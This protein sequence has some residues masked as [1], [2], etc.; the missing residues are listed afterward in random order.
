MRIIREREESVYFYRLVVI[1][2]ADN[3][4]MNIHVEKLGKGQLG[5]RKYFSI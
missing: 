3:Q 2:R 5:V 1:N 4:I